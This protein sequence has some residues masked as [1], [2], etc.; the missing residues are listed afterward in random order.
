MSEDPKKLAAALAELELER[1]RRINERVES[2]KAIR[3]QPIVVGAPESVEAE[4]SRR[5]A[6]ISH[7]S[8]EVIFGDTTEEGEPIECIVTGVPRAGR[9]PD[10]AAAPAIA[11]QAK[12]REGVALPVQTA[13]GERKISVQHS[14]A[15]KPQPDTSGRHYRLRVTISPTSERDCGFQID[16]T[17]TVSDQVRVYDMSGKL[18]GASP[19]NP[20]DD[21]EVLARKLLRSKSIGGGGFYGALNYPPRSFH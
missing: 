5:L 3:V 10:V 17:F 20:G 15:P 16:G 14:V 21:V 8:R 9:D 1:E 11:S 13:L 18:I 4:R 19:F 7:E 12:K 6:E 2:G